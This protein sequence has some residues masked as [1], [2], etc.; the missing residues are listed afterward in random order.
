ME[1]TDFVIKTGGPSLHGKVQVF[2]DYLDVRFEDG[3]PH[4]LSA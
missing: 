3:M 4:K 2:A 1:L